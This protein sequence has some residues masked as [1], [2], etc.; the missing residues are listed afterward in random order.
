MTKQA[1]V[2]IAI[3]FVL[4]C[5]ALL[6]SGQTQL[7]SVHGTVVDP[8][9]AVVPS[10]T[11]T[12]SGQSG[13]V[14][15]V[16]SGRNGA[17]AMDSVAPGTYSLTAV[18]SGFAP[19]DP[20]VV[21]VEGS[22]TTLETIALK[23]AIATQEVTVNDQ[24][25]TVNTSAEG[26]ASSL[27]IKDKDL[28]ALSDDP[29]ELQT[30]LTALAGP[31]AGPSGGQIYIDGFSG[32]QLPPKSSIREIRVNSNPFSAQY[33]KLGYGRIE[34]LTKPGTDKLRGMFMIDG[35]DS[36]FNSLNPF[37]KS[38]PPYYSTFLM[39][40]IG[41]AL[42]K[43]SSWTANVFDRNNASDAIIN[44]FVL[45]PSGGAVAYNAAV[46]S[47]SSNLSLSTR[48]DVQL[49]AKDTLTA[50]Y[51]FGR[52]TATNSG[53]GQFALETQSINSSGNM[54]DLQL[55]NSYVI[56]SNV[57]NETRLEYSRNSSTQAA[58]D[59]DPTIMV[60]G[61]FTGGGNS[62]GTSKNNLD[63]YE[64][65]NNTIVSHGPQSIN[66]GAR[67]RFD[68][69]SSSSTAGNNGAYIY[70]SLAAYQA[71]TPSQYSV[72]AGAGASSVNYFDAGVYFQDDYKARQNLTLSYGVRYE[73]QNWI[74][75][76][77]DFAPRFSFAWAPGGSGS[78]QAKTVIRG[79]Y[80]WFFDRFGET[81]IQQT[82]LENGVNQ[83]RY[84]VNNPT[85][86][87]NAPSPSA[88]AGSASTAAP[89]I[90]VLAPNLKAAINMQ[91]AIG[92][93]RQLGKSSTVSATFINS[94]GLHQAFSDNINA[95][96]PGTYD[97]V[98][99][100][101]TRPNGVNENIDQFQS[102][103]MY[104]ENQ[105]MINYS[106]AIKRVSLF[107]F[108]SLSFANADTSGAGYFPSNQFDPMADYGRAN[109]DVR[110]RFLIGGN[111]TA[112]FG[113]S[114]SPMLSTNSGTPFNIVLGQDLNGD[115]EFNDRPAFATTA[116]A[117]TFQTSYGTFDLSPASN[118]ARI[119]Y[120]YGTAPSQF[121]MNL[122][123]SKS[124]GLGPRV[125]GGR[126]GGMGG[127]GGF[128]G[129]G[130]PGGGGPP[131]GGGGMGGL[132]PGGL[133]GRPNMPGMQQ[134]LAPRRYSLTLTANA[135]NVFNTV[136]LAAPISVLPINAAT[137]SQFG[138]VNSIAG[139]FF[140]S[141][142]S[143]RTIDL[144]ASFSF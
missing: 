30:E 86:Y 6:A 66:F 110:N 7:G 78:K 113:I 53:V 28:D 96:I 67:F 76:H 142:A 27:V 43:S 60:Q 41:G 11:V 56:R 47:P 9:G 42:T 71:H 143:N 103:G 12:L 21:V 144:Q 49:G 109:F 90:A 20:V 139:G 125:V 127:F 16:I 129:P 45:G 74:S 134:Q 70:Q 100:T 65:Q 33:D 73:A 118:Q 46:A 111:I 81:S 52:Q 48:F 3:T 54:S 132:G 31:S 126:G 38:E 99:G 84:I 58:Q 24:A 95:F 105:L 75:D 112:P 119:P 94:R 22:K 44:A 137:P 79:G 55:S 64:F 97:A 40:N 39:G 35:N 106:V 92:L 115:G 69:S 89:T 36:A 98:T 2:S 26:N 114:L 87:L 117:N 136:N 91:T 82:I 59:N 62:A 104:K 4:L 32:G 5:G 121:A 135:R 122:R 108:Y 50:R 131:P 19:F 116:G 77:A 25:S 120:N 133:S 107:G 15:A 140:G 13:V 141:A 124:F 8:S 37:V 102:E 138:V 123:A 93:E 88:L 101:G 10:A 85:F 57:V 80:G 23:I 29:N 72:T 68:Q 130:G 18:A 128:G 63:H 83:Q 51:A 17:F 1:I 14:K 34:I 61:A